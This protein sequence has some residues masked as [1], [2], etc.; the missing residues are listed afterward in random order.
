MNDQ[1]FY[2]DLDNVYEQLENTN[3]G[4]KI[5]IPNPILECTTTNTYFKNVKK[6]LIVINRPPEHFLEYLNKEIHTGYWI[7]NSKSDGIGMIGKISNKTI[8]SVLQNYI[9][10]YVV[11]NICK[12][13][14]TVL[15]KNKDLRIYYINCNKCKSKYAI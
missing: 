10:K 15:D 3:N 8:T 7:S 1:E 14:D 2:D 4:S 9:K 5:V 11:C 12:S 13:L 6:I